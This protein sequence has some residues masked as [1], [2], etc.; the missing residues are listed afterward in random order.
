[1]P[2]EILRALDADVRRLLAAGG[3]SAPAD[4]G[5]RR[6]GEALRE[7]G[8]KVPALAQVAAVVDRVTDAPVEQATAPLLDLLIRTRSAR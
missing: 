1:M 7:P 5:L 4:E 6:R 3:A 8:R 2:R